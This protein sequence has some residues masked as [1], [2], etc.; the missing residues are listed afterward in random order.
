MAG[1]LQ[2][3]TYL[4]CVYLVFKAFEIFQIALMSSRENRGVGLS[5]GIGAIL[6]ALV[7][8]YKFTTWIDEQARAMSQSSQ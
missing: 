1:M 2:I 6:I 7:L 4:L 3:I 8:A 5:F